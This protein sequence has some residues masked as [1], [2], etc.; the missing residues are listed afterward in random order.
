[1]S[2]TTTPPHSPPHLT[3]FSS[4][5]WLWA[6][7]KGD[8]REQQHVQ[9]WQRLFL[10]ETTLRARRVASNARHFGSSAA[11]CGCLATTCG[12]VS[13]LF[14]LFSP[15]CPSEK[16]YDLC[17]VGEWLQRLDNYK[18]RDVKSVWCVWKEWNVSQRFKLCSFRK[19]VLD[20][21]VYEK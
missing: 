15:R 11:F 21:G 4:A 8:N 18:C 1:M 2:P 19:A 7:G 12:H 9:E 20:A 14:S 17:L 6:C 5:H 3:P 13:R 10:K 16:S